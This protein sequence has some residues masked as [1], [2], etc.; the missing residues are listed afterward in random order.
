MMVR[1]IWGGAE[2][3]IT[4]SQDVIYQV[5]KHQERAFNTTEILN[6]IGEWFE[7]SDVGADEVNAFVERIAADTALMNGVID[8]YQRESR[9]DTAHSQ[10]VKNLDYA[11]RDVKEEAESEFGITLSGDSG[12]FGGRS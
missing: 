3:E 2:I 11:L 5:Y 10:D 4:L 9:N 12:G 7:D 1:A 8:T 6:R